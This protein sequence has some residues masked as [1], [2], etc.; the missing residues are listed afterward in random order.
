MFSVTYGRMS[1]EIPPARDRMDAGGRPRK[2]EKSG[3]AT[4]AFALTGHGLVPGCALDIPERR[5][6]SRECERAVQG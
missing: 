6:P 1:E 4:S 5:V 3:I 2:R